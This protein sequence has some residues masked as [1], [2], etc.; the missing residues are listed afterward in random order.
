MFSLWAA[1]IWNVD[2]R[3]RAYR[4]MKN[5]LLPMQTKQGRGQSHTIWGWKAECPQP[6]QGFPNL[7]DW[8]PQY[9]EG[10]GREQRSFCKES[11]REWRGR[12]W[13]GRAFS[14][15]QPCSIKVRRAGRGQLP[16]QENSRARHEADLVI[17][18]RLHFVDR[19]KGQLFI[20][21]IFSMKPLE[22]CYINNVKV[23]QSFE[24]DHCFHLTVQ[25][26]FVERNCWCMISDSSS[27]FQFLRTSEVR[28]GLFIQ[29][30]LPLL[31]PSQRDPSAPF[32]PVPPP[33]PT[34]S[35]TLEPQPRMLW[36]DLQPLFLWHNQVL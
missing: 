8:S 3:L 35:P 17:P 30:S 18:C 34:P 29:I 11:S 32:L 24:S 23:S 10:Q 1:R 31:S 33:L 12:G 22:F 4:I 21:E 25:P 6:A 26:K 36:N 16:A 14:R 28:F 20:P 5:L 9:P 2:Q 19:N 13:K 7:L 27:A 15:H